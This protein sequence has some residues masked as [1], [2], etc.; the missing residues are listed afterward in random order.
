MAIDF[1]GVSD[2]VTIGDV[3][4]I[5][6]TGA[7]MSLACWF[8]PDGTGINQFLIS[9]RNSGVAIQYG[10]Y[11]NNSNQ[12]QFEFEDGGTTPAADTTTATISAGSWQHA[13]GVCSSQNGEAFLNGT[14]SGTP[15]AGP[16]IGNTTNVL[17]IGEAGSVATDN[18]F[19]FNGRICEVA[20]WDVAL[21]D[22]EVMSLAN[23]VLPIYV[24]RNSLKGYWP[25]WT[26]NQLQDLSGNNNPGTLTGGAYGAHAP[27]MPLLG[28]EGEEMY[29]VSAA[30]GLQGGMMLLG[31]G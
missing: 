27:V 19:P 24:R 1:A 31:V 14:G 21:S 8:N 15:A 7:N 12:I 30:A 16:L 18:D 28:G 3:A 17:K 4:A 9:K 23:G 20:I 10:L 29:A 5:D 2:D 6:I 13:A 22:G 26:T 11:V 25:L